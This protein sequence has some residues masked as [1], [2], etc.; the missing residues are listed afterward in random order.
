MKLLPI[1][2]I[3]TNI[4]TINSYKGENNEAKPLHKKEAFGYAVAGGVLAT[5]AA[6]FFIIRHKL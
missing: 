2:K 4:S 3:I 5:G 1:S 6:A